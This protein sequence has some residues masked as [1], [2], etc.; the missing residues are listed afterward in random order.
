M[1]SYDPKMNITGRSIGFNRLPYIIAELSANHNGSLERALATITA[2][3]QCG[4]DAVKIQT[5][6][7]DT[8]TIECDLPD[9]MV[10]GGLWDGYKLY[11]LYKE[12]QTPYEWHKPLFEHAK[13]EGITLFST[14]FDETAVDLLES[15]DTP[16]YKI[17][18]FELT[19]LPLIEYVARTGKP[20][21]LSTGMATEHEIE[22]AVT[23]A[24]DSGCKELIL[25]HCISSY[26]API[27]QAHLRQISALAKRFKLPVGLSDHTQ[28]T[29]ASVAAVAIGAC[30]I[31]KH[32]TLNRAD[33]G[34]DCEFSLEPSELK[35]LCQDV[36]NTWDAL[37][38]S[39]FG[40]EKT[41]ESSK[42][43][44]RS[45]YFVNDL[46]AGHILKDGDIRKIRPGMGMPPKA[47]QKILGLRLRE[48]VKRGTAVQENLFFNNV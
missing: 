13:K 35:R 36:K 8:M 9:F 30:V 43:F 22:E 38:S 24:R 1:P 40:R 44:R 27:E 45:L 46:P 19:D 41:E 3:K 34:P 39:E 16:A 15:L 14:P 6:T 48:S 11:D 21:I 2:A 26:P 10:K 7:A 20:M 23:T 5:Y 47:L 37:G 25:L 18:S 31:E 42:V 29:T 17:A 33:K 12:A 32:F 4:A 28:G